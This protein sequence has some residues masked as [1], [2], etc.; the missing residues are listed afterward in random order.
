[1]LWYQWESVVYVMRLTQENVTFA[2]PVFSFELK[3]VPCDL[4][5]KVLLKPVMLTCSF[6]FC[7]FSFCRSLEWNW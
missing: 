4:K 2:Q 5:D 7:F 3:T 1:M 6:V